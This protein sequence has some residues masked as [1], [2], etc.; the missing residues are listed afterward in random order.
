MNTP[1]K[2]C[3]VCA[4]SLRLSETPMKVASPYLYAGEQLFWIVAV[5][6]FALTWSLGDIGYAIAAVVA[7]LVVVVVF[8]KSWQRAQREAV[9]ERG[10]YYCESC[11]RHFEGDSLRQ[12]TNWEPPH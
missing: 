3:P 2:S 9:A 4:S 11:H 6:V 7:I 1:A 8:R 12:L 10:K 5:A